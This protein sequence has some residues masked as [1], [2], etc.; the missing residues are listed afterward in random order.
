M[1]ICFIWNSD[2]LLYFNWN[3]LQCETSSLTSNCIVTPAKSKNELE[4]TKFNSLETKVRTTYSQKTEK[5]QRATKLLSVATKEYIHISEQL[6]R[7][8]DESQ[9]FLKKRDEKEK[10]AHTFLELNKRQKKF[11]CS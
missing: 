10:K 9:R 7:D 6:L 4:C 1:R 11:A 8:N 2:S 3:E 5:K